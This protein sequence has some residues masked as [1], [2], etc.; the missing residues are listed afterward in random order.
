MATRLTPEQIERLPPELLALALLQ[1]IPERQAVRRGHVFFDVLKE[2][3]PEMTQMATH[4]DELMTEYPAATLALAEA[5]QR[6]V[7][8]GLI[9]NWPTNDPRYRTETFGEILQLTRFG[10]QVRARGAGGAHLV[11][12]RRRLGVELHPRLAGRLR[13]TVAVGA[14]ERAALLALRGIEARVRD[15]TNDPRGKRGERLTGT[16]LMQHAFSPEA[17]PLADPDAEPGERVGAMSLFV[18]AFGAVR[19]GLVHTEVEWADPV[20]GA[21]YVLL[22]DLLM[23]MLDRAAQ[24]VGS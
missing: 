7:L 2:A 20:D 3:R 12:A 4:S 8:D 13:E 1:R 22:A 5:W 10:R 11:A 9:V 19:N 16:A 15:L 6:L 18:G 14:F 17:G 21:E 24:R 23:R